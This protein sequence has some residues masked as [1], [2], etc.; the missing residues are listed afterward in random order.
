MTNSATI[1]C[2]L[3]K[4][5][6]LSEPQLLCLKNWAN[7]TP[8]L[9]SVIHWSFCR[10]GTRHKR[11]IW[12]LFLLRRALALPAQLFCLVSKEGSVLLDSSVGLLQFRINRKKEGREVRTGS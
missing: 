4:L 6:I 3:G 10:L 11:F 5:L 9:H 1:P 12:F 7:D 2:Q 8:L